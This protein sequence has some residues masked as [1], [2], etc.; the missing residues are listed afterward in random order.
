MATDHPKVNEQLAQEILLDDPNFL[1][2]IVERVLQEILEAEMT[3]HIG[4]APYERSA[5]RTGLRKR[6][7]AEDLEDQGRHPQPAGAPAS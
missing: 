6:L 4:A 5:A 2:E 1:R 3:E 7:Q